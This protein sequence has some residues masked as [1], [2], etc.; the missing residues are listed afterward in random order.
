VLDDTLFTTAGNQSPSLFR[1]C[2]S[3]SGDVVLEWNSGPARL[4]ALSSSAMGAYT[5]TSSS[6]MCMAADMCVCAV[7]SERIAVATSGGALWVLGGQS[8][9]TSTEVL[10]DP[11]TDGSVW[12]AGPSLSACA[13][14]ISAGVHQWRPVCYAPFHLLTR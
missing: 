11:L 13:G 6:T 10:A 7:R 8:G 4:K 9:D 3:A 2:A 12:R 5:H 14:Q 1:G